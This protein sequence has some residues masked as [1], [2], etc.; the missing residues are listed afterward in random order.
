MTDLGMMYDASVKRFSTFAIVATA[1]LSAGPAFA[2]DAV[3]WN[4]TEMIPEGIV[5]KNLTT[6]EAS[7][8]GIYVQT[9][10][11]GMLQLPPPGI[12]ADALT[13][14]VTNADTPKLAFVWQTADLGPGE[15]YQAE[16]NLPHGQKQTANVALHQVAEWDPD[17]TMVGIAF[18]AGSEVLIRSMEWRSYSPLEKLWNGV[19]SFWTPDTFSLYSINFLWGPLIGT[20]PEARATLFA[21]LPPKAWSATRLFYGAL[22]LAAVGGAAYA[23]NKPDRRKTFLGV[24]AIA[25]AAAWTLFD[26]RMTQEIAS[27]AAHDWK[28]YVLA[29]DDDRVLR[30]H[31]NLYD[32]IADIKELLGEDGSYALLAPEGTPFFANVRYA[33]YPAMPVPAVPGS[34]AKG[35]IVLGNP[36]VRIEGESL[37]RADGTVLVP[38]GAIVKRFDDASFFFRALP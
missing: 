4:F 10:T 30:T 6:V 19:V 2:M 18:P 8:E 23:R 32:V 38:R 9:A 7:N 35:W 22:A 21:T 12:D 11:D 5:P 27:Y 15:F 28:T 31:A 36:A 37:V 29:G 13:M 16:I 25:G 26:A 3:P 14:V 20:T 33:L 24:L 34:D 17:A 1:L